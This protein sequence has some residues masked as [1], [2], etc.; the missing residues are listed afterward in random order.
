[1][2]VQAIGVVTWL[3]FRKGFK[4]A[5][6]SFH[7]LQSRLN[8]KRLIEEGRGWKKFFDKIVSFGLFFGEVYQEGGGGT[9]ESA[10]KH[11]YIILPENF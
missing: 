5:F 11:C 9:L 7:V 4:C 8:I 2:T 10:L 6:C 3:D 1:M